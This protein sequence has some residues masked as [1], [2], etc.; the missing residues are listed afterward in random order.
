MEEDDF[1]LLCLNEE[2]E[3]SL[4][5][6]LP[7]IFSILRLG[8]KIHQGT[9]GKITGK[10]ISTLLKYLNVSL[11][12]LDLEGCLD[13]AWCENCGDAVAEAFVQHANKMVEAGVPPLPMFRE[14]N[15]RSTG[16]T[17]DG[18]ERLLSLEDNIPQLKVL[19]DEESL[20]G[21]KP[22]RRVRAQQRESL[23]SQSSYRSLV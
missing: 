13:L 11:E 4:P 12:V 7:P 1:I 17:R 14:L 23:A 22:P 15:L 19:Y 10:G 18:L 8:S 9:A 16:L 3:A 2:F 20:S 21:E 6:D 5:A